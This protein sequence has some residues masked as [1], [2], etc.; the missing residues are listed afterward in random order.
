MTDD[1]Y[2]AVFR[3]PFAEASSF[4]RDK[5]NIP[6]DKWDDIWKEQ[7]A[8]GFMS[9]GA[10]KADLLSDLRG[11][12]QKA[13]DG[14]TTLAEFQSGFDKVVAKNG[15]SYNGSRNWRSE[16]IYDTNITTAYQAGRW[17]Q[18]VEAGTEYLMYL[19]MDGV[20]HP[21]LEHVAW[22]GTV[23]PITDP[24]WGTHY[25]PNGWRCHCRAVRATRPDW[26]KAQA[27]GAGTAPTA[28]GNTAGIDEGWDYNVGKAAYGTGPKD[29]PAKWRTLDYP[30][31][32]SPRPA[33]AIPLDS[34][35]QVLAPAVHSQA[36]MVE[37][38]RAAIGG[39]SASYLFEEKGLQYGVN[40]D[41]KWLGEHLAYDRA[42][43]LAYLPGL[44]EDPAEVWLNWEQNEDTGKIRVGMNILKAIELG[45][46]KGV[47]LAA[48][49][50]KGELEGWTFIPTN[51]LK[52]LDKQR[53][54]L[55]V[56]QR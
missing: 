32:Q 18:F 3:L 16:L 26:A 8:K 5:L 20:T 51:D 56:Y 15:W 40:I 37:A 46:G 45:K 31:A 41:A 7:H 29:D 53:K 47:F 17:Q 39:D 14:K 10:A 30:Q 25:P 49:V 44:L 43:Y 24:W 11:E 54:G 33:A 13:I 21:R 22:S 50:A 35:M 55:L 36:A 4:F 9:A 12:V 52:Y 19:H 2:N 1:E 38:I 27:A 28:P 48:K 42:P 23:L 34:A 6:T